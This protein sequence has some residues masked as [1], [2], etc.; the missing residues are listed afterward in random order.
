MTFTIRYHLI[1]LCDELGIPEK[2]M[3]SINTC[4]ETFI[5]SFII[6][7]IETIWRQ[8]VVTTDQSA[9]YQHFK[10]QFKSKEEF[11][12]VLRQY[13]KNHFLDEA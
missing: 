6:S 5:I 11:Q 1:G 2:I 3:E 8:M 4:G 7:P 9:K 10:K 12:K 13:P